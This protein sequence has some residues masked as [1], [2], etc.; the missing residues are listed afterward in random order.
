METIFAKTPLILLELN[1][2]KQYS[3]NPENEDTLN[4][5]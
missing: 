2:A 1:K 5:I 3:F 4:D